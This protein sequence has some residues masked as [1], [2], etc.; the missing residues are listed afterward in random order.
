MTVRTLPVRFQRG[1]TLVEILVVVVIIG[2]LSGLAVPKFIQITG[3][4]QLDGD[5][6]TFHQEILWARNASIRTGNPY[7]IVL[8]NKEIDGTKRATWIIQE[9]QKDET[10][11]KF[12]AKKV[13]PVQADASLSAGVSVLWGRPD[14]ITEPT[15]TKFPILTNLA[16]ETNGFKNTD[17]TKAI[18]CFQPLGDGSSSKLTVEKWSDGITFCGGATGLMERGG[19]YMMSTRSSSRAYF[20]GANSDESVTPKPMRYIGSAWE[21]L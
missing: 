17:G 5:F 3:E 12:T 2:I 16:T 6:N 8:E 21:A 1:F 10:G 14:E 15:A 11:T 19:V 4:N 18:N 7:V 20:I 9:M 13:R